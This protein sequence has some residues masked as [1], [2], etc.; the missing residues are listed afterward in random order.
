MR[1]MEKKEEISNKKE[2]L[3]EIQAKN[4]QF[5]TKPSKKIKIKRQFTKSELMCQDLTDDQCEELRNLKFTNKPGDLFLQVRSL[6]E[7]YIYEIREAKMEWDKKIKKAQQRQSNRYKF[8]LETKKKEIQYDIKQ[9][10]KKIEANLEKLEAQEHMILS[11]I[12]VIYS[13]NKDKLV[14]EA[15]KI[16]NFDFMGM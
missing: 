4:P 15:L 13:M 1:K 6:E 9:V 2:N 5:L 8:A 11:E 14:D 10:I 7:R 16:I 3:K 12:D